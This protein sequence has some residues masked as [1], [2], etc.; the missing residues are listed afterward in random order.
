MQRSVRVAARDSKLSKAQVEEVYLAINQF[1]SVAFERSYYKTQGDIDLDTPLMD[2]EKTDFFTQ[3]LDLLVKNNEVDL[4]IHS[5]KDLP[6]PLD[7][8][9]ELIALTNGVDPSDVLV[10]VKYTLATLPAQAK[11]GVSSFRR[12][13]GLFQIRQDLKFL[14]IRG[15]VDERLKLLEEGVYDALI[16]AE[17]GLF[18]LKSQV[19]RERLDIPVS[20]LQGKLALVAKKGNLEMKTLFAPLDARVCG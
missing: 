5:A 14:S 15:A 18:R 20:P 8:D 12:I 17:A 2:L 13:E 3:T 6:E 1:Y 9:L 10:S 16:L 19:S 7:P 4:A 11:I